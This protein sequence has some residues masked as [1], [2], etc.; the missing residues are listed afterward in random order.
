MASINDVFNALNDIKG[1]LDVLHADETTLRG[2]VDTTNNRL[3]TL[4]A[5]VNNVGATLEARLVEIR[6]E[7]QIGNGIAAHQ[8]Q[9]LETVICSLDLIA[10][11]LCSLLNLA[12]VDSRV[13]ASLAEHARV[14]A[15]I[16][17]SAHP[18]AALDLARR[19]AAEA[20]LKACCPDPEPDPACR[21][22]RCEDPD[23]Y[24]GPTAADRSVD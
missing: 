5:S 9:Q 6:T 7:E 15:D 1:K 18:D 16:A 17:R 8:T 23:P 4:D 2:K 20:A 21:H 13:L 3:S 22:E 12:A 24:K 10:D 19:D 14:T 11:R